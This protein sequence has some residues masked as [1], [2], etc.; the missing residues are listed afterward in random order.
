LPPSLRDSRTFPP[1][2]LTW[3]L[4]E[5]FEED[6][7][8]SPYI[9]IFQQRYLTKQLTIKSAERSLHS[10]PTGLTHGHYTRVRVNAINPYI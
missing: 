2:E 6:Y 10:I 5:T 3:F 7:I 8:P 9:L 4:I 1:E